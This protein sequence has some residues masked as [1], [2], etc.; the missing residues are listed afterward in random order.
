MYGSALFWAL[1]TS[2]RKLTRNADAVIN[3][4]GVIYP[5]EED[6]STKLPSAS[7]KRTTKPRLKVRLH[8]SYIE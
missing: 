6:V 1:T 7:W 2:E 4:P 8:A 3:I 5:L